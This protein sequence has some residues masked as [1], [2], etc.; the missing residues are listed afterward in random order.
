MKLNFVFNTDKIE[1]SIGIVSEFL[2]DLKSSGMYHYFPFMDGTL[3]DADLVQAQIARDTAEFHPDNVSKQL[4]EYWEAHEEEINEALSEYLTR[5]KLSVLPS[6]TCALTFYGP[7]GYYHTPDVVYLNIT[8]GTTEFM[9]QTLLHEFLHLVLFERVKDLPDK[10]VETII[11]KTFL[12]IFGEL[13]P[14]YYVQ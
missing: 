5:E 11:D 9:I 6:Y 14:D 1:E 2:P 8:K 7:Y 3:K 4:Q 10:E 12:E 13:F